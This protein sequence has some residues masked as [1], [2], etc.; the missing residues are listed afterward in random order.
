[1]RPS[2][3]GISSAA[4]SPR[5]PGPADDLGTGTACPILIKGTRRHR[6]WNGGLSSTRTTTTNAP[7]A[8]TRELHEGWAFTQV[9]GGPATEEGEWLPTQ[10]FPTTVHVEL[11][12]HKKIPDPVSVCPRDGSV[13]CAEIRCAAVV[14]RAARVGRAMWVTGRGGA[15]SIRSVD[16]SVALQ[17]SARSNGPSG[18]PSP[19]ARQRLPPRTWILCLTAWIRLR[20]SSW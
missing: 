13:S 5:R 6:S 14:H 20:S 11:L 19:R 10:S 4:L 17:G 18:P 1:M 15:C 9:G 16:T 2:A 12:A 7:M 8:T 3:G